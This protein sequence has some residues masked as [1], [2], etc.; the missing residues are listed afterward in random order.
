[1]A[2]MFPTAHKLD[3]GHP[4]QGNTRKGGCRTF[5]DAAQEARMM[6]EH[7]SPGTTSNTDPGCIGK[8]PYLI[9]TLCLI[10]LA[11][12]QQAQAIGRWQ[13]HLSIHHLLL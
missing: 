12:K 11:L 1:M 6:E 4:F 13:G 2:G 8:F 10:A 5:E 3:A 7:M 9:R